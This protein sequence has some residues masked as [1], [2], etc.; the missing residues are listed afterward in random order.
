V[1]KKTGTPQAEVLDA[2]KDA[3]ARWIHARAA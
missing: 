3:I 1:P 2:V